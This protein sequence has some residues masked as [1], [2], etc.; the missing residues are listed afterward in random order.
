MLGTMLLRS[1]IVATVMAA[2]SPALAQVPA[3]LKPSPGAL[4]GW[5]VT[6]DPADPNRAR[7]RRAGGAGGTVDR[8]LVLQPWPSSAY[9]TAISTL[10]AAL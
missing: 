2:A 8:I 6:T 7:V 4:A 5:Q 3:W 1:L 9:D 10:R